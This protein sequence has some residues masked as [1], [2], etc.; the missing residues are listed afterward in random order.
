MCQNLLETL[1]F[2][3]HIP[4]ACYKQNYHLQSAVCPVPDGHL[5]VTVTIKD[6]QRKWGRNGGHSG[7]K[8]F[9]G[10][11]LIAIRHVLSLSD[12]LYANHMCKQS[13]KVQKYQQNVLKV[14][15]V[16]VLIVESWPL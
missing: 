3:L 11:A 7:Q 10:S 13:S 8:F 1:E 9:L 5:K 2:I 14:S 15:K 4:D 6:A 12:A 16:N